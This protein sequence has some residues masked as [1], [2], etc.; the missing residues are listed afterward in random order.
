MVVSGEV[1]LFL[2]E[3]P[4]YQTTPDLKREIRDATSRIRSACWYLDQHRCVRG[5]E[6]LAA[7]LRMFPAERDEEESAG[8]GARGEGLR[9]RFCG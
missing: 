1:A 9:V 4:L 8:I 6:S 5:R 7:L 2:S 3:A